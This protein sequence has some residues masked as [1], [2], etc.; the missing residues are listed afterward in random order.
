MIEQMILLGLAGFRLASLISTER[1]PADV[2]I[3]FR[4]LF[5]FVH[6]EDGEVV[7]HPPTTF[8]RGLACM[9]C[10]SVWMTGGAWLAWQIEPVLVLLPAAAAVAFI[11]E[12]VVRPAAREVRMLN[13]RNDGE[14]N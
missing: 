11:V 13:Q 10:S 3:R 5:G 7:S 1:G 14:V 9:W 12:Q 8:A 2:F 6:N 4:E